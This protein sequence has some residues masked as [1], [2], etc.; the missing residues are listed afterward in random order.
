MPCPYARLMVGRRHC[1][2]LVRYRGDGN[3]VSLR[4]IVGKRHCRLLAVS[5]INSEANGFDIIQD[6]KLPN[7]STINLVT[8]NK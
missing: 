7:P 1:R 6:P 3:A 2:V 4:Q 5:N 8:I